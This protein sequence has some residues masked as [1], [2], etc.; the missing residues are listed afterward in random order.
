MSNPSYN[1]VNQK[2]IFTVKYKNI[3]KEPYYKSK[4]D[5]KSNSSKILSVK[6]NF[7]CG[8]IPNITDKAQT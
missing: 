2:T 7:I 6:C 8:S 1:F 3:S 5:L 4:L